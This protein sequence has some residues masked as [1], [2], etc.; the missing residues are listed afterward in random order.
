M[1]QKRKLESLLEDIL[2]ELNKNGIQYFNFTDYNM[3][4]LVMYQKTLDVYQ[5]DKLGKN[6]EEF[7]SDDDIL[8]MD[9]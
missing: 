2:I 4:Q 3:E 8:D 1:S 7:S 5:E 9:D 6:E